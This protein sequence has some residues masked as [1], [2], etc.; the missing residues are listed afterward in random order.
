M[1]EDDDILWKALGRLGGFL[2]IALILALVR[3][4]VLSA[5]W[6]WFVVPL[7][8]KELSI[9]HAI[10]LAVIV[11]FLTYQHDAAKDSGSSENE[12][13]LLIWMIRGI[14]FSGMAW[15]MGALIHLYM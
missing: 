10:G 2:L 4:Y 8:V 7:G 11:N 15:G 13:P 12:S 9:A 3:G 1:A 6:G 5:L 14:V